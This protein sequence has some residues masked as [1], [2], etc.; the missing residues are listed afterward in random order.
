MPSPLNLSDLIDLV[1]IKNSELPPRVV[2]AAVRRVFAEITQ[3]LAD[4]GRVEIRGFGVL[5]VKQLAAIEGRHPSTGTPIQVPARKSVHWKT[6]K[7]LGKA[8]NEPAADLQARQLARRA[9]V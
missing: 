6:S 4:G 5:E 9:G 3:A 1:Q 8:L 2:D 7:G